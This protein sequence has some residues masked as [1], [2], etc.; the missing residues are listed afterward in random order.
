MNRLVKN[1][2]IM[3]IAPIF[4][5]TLSLMLVPI[6]TRYYSPEDFG[7]FSL[8]GSIITPFAVFANLGYGSAIV[9]AQSDDEA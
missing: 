6:I 1:M 3:S 9:S 2:A 4:T 7:M 8:Y 5:Q